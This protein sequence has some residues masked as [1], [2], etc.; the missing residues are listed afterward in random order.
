MSLDI[1]LEP[2]IGYQRYKMVLSNSR[3]APILNVNL[4]LGFKNACF[5][6]Q[7]CMHLSP[8]AWRAIIHRKGK[9]HSFYARTTTWRYANA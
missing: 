5:R 4:S 8:Q 3:L 1:G 6:R 9:L 7:Y 2:I